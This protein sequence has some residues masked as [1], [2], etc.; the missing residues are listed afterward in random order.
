MNDPV[1][2]ILGFIGLLALGA[3]LYWIMSD[4]A[5]GLRADRERIEAQRQQLAE[6]RQQ[7][8]ADREWLK[9][10]AGENFPEYHAR[11]SAWRRAGTP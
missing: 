3:V 5:E 11:V 8:D 7:L 4:M 6:R 2:L 9:M 10:R 1:S